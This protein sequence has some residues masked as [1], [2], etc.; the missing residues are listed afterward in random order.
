MLTHPFFLLNYKIFRR[1]NTIFQLF[2]ADHLAL[3]PL[4]LA[5]ILSGINTL[6]LYQAYSKQ[7]TR[8]LTPF[9]YTHSNK[10]RN[11]MLTLCNKMATITSINKL[12]GSLYVECI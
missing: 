4:K 10:S 7:I 12:L 9:F 11:I 6:C 8:L 5:S 2:K 3:E 1:K